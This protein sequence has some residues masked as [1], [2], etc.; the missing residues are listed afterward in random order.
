MFNKTPANITVLNIHVSDAE[1][2]LLTGMRETAINA[3][4]ERSHHISAQTKG[5]KLHHFLRIQSFP[6]QD[7]C[8]A[9]TQQ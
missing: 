6:D 3:G 9:Q 7:L 1:I 2:Y 4:L 8:A 5:C